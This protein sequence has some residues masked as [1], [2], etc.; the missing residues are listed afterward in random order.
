[1]LHRWKMYLF[2]MKMDS[3]EESISRGFFVFWKIIKSYNL[4]KTRNTRIIK[5]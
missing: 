3:I 2:E 1:M 5:K 4:L